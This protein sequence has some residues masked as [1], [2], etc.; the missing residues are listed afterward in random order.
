MSP[1]LRALAIAWIGTT[2]VAA[3]AVASG[4][5]TTLPPAVAS[6]APP[7]PIILQDGV[8]P[9]A[10]ELLSTWPP[11]GVFQVP[12]LLQ[13][14]SETFLYDVFVDFSSQANDP[15]PLPAYGPVAETPSGTEDGGVAVAYFAL[16]PPSVS[17]TTCHTIYF[18]VVH[19]F[20]VQDG[21]PPGSIPQV[22]YHVPDSVGGDSVTWIYAPGGSLDGCPFYDAGIF[23]DGATPPDGATDV[24]AAGADAL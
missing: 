8:F 5:F 13:D 15:N 14:P 9:P 17:P 1:R 7:R 6:T 11:D 4:C 12:V 20:A 10:D 2:A 18:L 23:E 21:G 16:G 22:L 24:S 19:G 3:G